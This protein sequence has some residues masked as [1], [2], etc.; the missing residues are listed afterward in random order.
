MKKYTDRELMLMLNGIAFTVDLLHK[1]SKG[2]IPNSTQLTDMA[3]VK[4]FVTE[5]HSKQPTVSFQELDVLF[6]KLSN[7]TYHMEVSS[8]EEELMNLPP[9]SKYLS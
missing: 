9:T 3:T 5:I 8:A 4:E 6:T 1:T 7:L 2:A